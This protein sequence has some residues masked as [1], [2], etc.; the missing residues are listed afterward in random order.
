MEA[1]ALDE[2]DVLADQQ[3]VD[4][5]GVVADLVDLGV[6]AREQVEGPVGADAVDAG[7]RRQPAVGDVALLVQPCLLY[8]SPSPRDS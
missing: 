1:G 4:E 7:D 3:V 8:T 6:E 2:Q 5:A